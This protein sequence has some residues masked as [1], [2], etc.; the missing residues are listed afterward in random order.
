MKGEDRISIKL[1]DEDGKIMASP[2]IPLDITVDEFIEKNSLAGS[3]GLLRK[4]SV[5][6][7]R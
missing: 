2:K 6:A 1:L 3:G 7:I 4:L 5:N